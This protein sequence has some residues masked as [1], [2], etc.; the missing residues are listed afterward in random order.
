MID[1][2]SFQAGAK[3]PT[4][5][6]VLYTVLLAFIL[7]TAISITYYFTTPRNKQSRSFFQAM[8]LASIVAST[9]MQAIGDS[10]A[11]GLGM[12]GALAIIRFRNTLEDPRDI[13]FMFA[14]LAAGLACGVYGFTIAL[15]GTLGF[16]LVALVLKIS[17]V[18]AESG[19]QVR[20]RF[21]QNQNE[22][23]EALEAV[24]HKWAKRISL[25]EMRVRQVDSAPESES[26]VVDTFFEYDYKI[27]LSSSRNY[28]NL[29]AELQQLSGIRNLRINRSSS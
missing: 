28:R 13:I 27:Q 3:Y 12:L 25:E 11:V 24:L 4:L 18:D 19:L 17:P 15:V 7:S 1:Y 21:Q 20:V 23:I 16:C 14:A 6:A 10:L 26:Q 8:V 5:S 22:D 29:V 9:V 2:F